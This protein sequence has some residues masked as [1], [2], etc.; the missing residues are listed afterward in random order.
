MAGPWQ[1]T[2]YYVQEAKNGWYGYFT[3]TEEIGLLQVH[4]DFGG[5]AHRWPVPGMPFKQFLIQ[6]ANFTHKFRNNVRYSGWITSQKGRN[7]LTNDLLAVRKHLWPLF[8]EQ[9]KAEL[10]E[11]AVTG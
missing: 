6:D 1:S 11:K 5:F 9:L 7:E 8:I 3:V 4:S 10:A 2:T